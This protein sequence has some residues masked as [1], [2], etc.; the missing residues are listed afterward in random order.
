VRV[1]GAVGAAALAAGVVTGLLVLAWPRAKRGEGH[2]AKRPARF[3]LRHAGLRRWVEARMDP[4]TATG[5]ALT[6]AL[7][8]VSGGLVAVGAVLA[9]VVSSTGLAR[10]DDAFARWGATN[11]SASGTDVAGYLTKLGGHEVVVALALLVVLAEWARGRGRHV[12][13]FLLAV[14][15]STTVLMNIVK[16]LVDRDR[17]DVLRLASFGGASFPSGHSALAAA[18]FAAFVLVL[19]RS[20]S[21]ATRAWLAGGAAAV[22]AAVA[23]TR[24]LLG[25]HWLTDVVAGLA[26][27]WACFAACAIAFGGRL[28]TFGAPVEL[29][30]RVAEQ[31][32]QADQAERAEGA[33]HADHR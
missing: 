31:A 16:V 15:G 17:P 5:L 13:W 3:L 12:A 30:A 27:G 19:G 21:R 8:V 11:V 23:S 18:A 24:V 7:A 22:A 33:E 29:A 20:R 26:L 28:L 4:G 9:M 1:I 2:A 32:E 6:A 10:L 14:V 25:V